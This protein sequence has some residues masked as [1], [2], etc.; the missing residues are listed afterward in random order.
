M[1]TLR[2]GNSII[3]TAI[4]VVIATIIILFGIVIMNTV[5]PTTLEQVA[6]NQQAADAVSQ[7]CSAFYKNAANITSPP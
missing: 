2:T 7:T 6:N 3:D 4:G 1:F 5:C